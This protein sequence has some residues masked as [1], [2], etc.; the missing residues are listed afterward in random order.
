M[1]PPLIC[2]SRFVHWFF[3]SS[4]TDRLC[5]VLGQPAHLWKL[6]SA[7]SPS[8]AVVDSGC[9]WARSDLMVVN[10]AKHQTHDLCGSHLLQVS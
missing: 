1:T 2:Y 7:D 10:N 8:H 3:Y 9:A 6:E 5:G 4:G